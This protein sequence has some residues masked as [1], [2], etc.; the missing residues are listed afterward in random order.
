MTCLG[1][2]YHLVEAKIES[3]WKDFNHALTSFF[4]LLAC[5]IS[6]LLITHIEH[7][8][9]SIT[10]FISGR[11]FF[12]YFFNLFEGKPIE[13][14]GSFKDWSAKSDT[15]IRDLRKEIGFE[16]EVV[17]RTISF[18]IFVIG[19]LFILKSGIL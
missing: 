17:L 14:L 18:Y 9:I 16:W 5:V 6:T 15:Y 7:I 11:I 4:T 3:K 8:W 2:L 13:Y 19:Q 10:S 1:I 12:D